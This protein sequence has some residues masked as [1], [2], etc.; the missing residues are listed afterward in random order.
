MRTPGG[1]WYTA[2]VAI[3]E[4]SEP[5]HLKY[6]RRRRRNA[7]IRFEAYAGRI[8]ED[9]VATAADD[10]AFKLFRIPKTPEKYVCVLCVYR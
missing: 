1:D 3:K 2:D 10:S 8:G 9:L 4:L 7:S 6:R 5:V